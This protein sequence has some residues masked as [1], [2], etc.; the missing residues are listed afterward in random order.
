MIFLEAYLLV[1]VVRNILAFLP[2][3]LARVVPRT[4][5]P[6]FAEIALLLVFRTTGRLLVV[7]AALVLTI[8]VAVF[9]VMITVCTV[10]SLFPSL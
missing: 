3:M 1:L 6:I 5:F 10:S 7:L 4:V 9:L 8:A 2:G